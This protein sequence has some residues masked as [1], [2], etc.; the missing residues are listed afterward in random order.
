MGIMWIDSE[1]TVSETAMAR[2]KIVPASRRGVSGA[3]RKAF[4]I[5][6]LAPLLL[7]LVTMAPT[8]Y[9]LDSAE[10]TTAAYTGGLVRATGYP[11]YLVV[12]RAWSRIPL[13]DV[14]Y[15]MNLLSAVCG[16]LTIGLAFKILRKLEIGNWASLG[17]LGLLATSYYFWGLS[18]IAEVYTPQT[19]LTCLI[20]LVLLYWAN[21]PSAQRLALAVFVVALSA[22]H[23]MATV[24]LAPGCL[25]FVLRV[26][27][28]DSLKPKALGYAGLSLILGLSIYLYL[29]LASLA[30][31][32]FNYAGQYSAQG[33]FQP[34]DLTTPH[35][36]WWLMSGQA[37]SDQM[38][39]YSKGSILAEVTHFSGELW[40]AFS[41]IGIGPGIVGIVVLWAKN[42][43]ICEMLLIMFLATVG[44]YVA[45]AVA[46]KDTM[47]LPAYL[48]WA[49]WVAVG[50]QWLLDW[51]SRHPALPYLQQENLGT[52]L[53]RAILLSGVVFSLIWH[54]PLVSLSSDRSARIRGEMILNIAAPESVVIGW[55][56]TVPVI[57]Y[58][59]MVEGRREDITA[60]NRFLIELPNLQKFV[61]GQIDHRVVYLDQR[62][63]S[64]FADLLSRRRGPLF[65]LERRPVHSGL[66]QPRL[67]TP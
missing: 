16:A 4:A 13:G 36:L 8:V 41:I 48:I 9:N 10:L 58:L 51:T 63:G 22:G 15:R 28:R 18:L 33:T 12:G 64:D 1:N 35:G 56:D 61:D 57:E 52:N 17:A 53:L 66:E 55:W 62:P 59:Q 38:M 27:P 49:I 23:H 47:F 46:D 37:F 45:Y 25:W 20:I 2:L 14:G 31:P 67:N 32:E 60:M 26:A 39:A 40:R 6:V 7:Y 11:L 65:Q 42:R 34:V 5:A 21:D 24:L 54:T 29:P 44:F 43:K 3:D 50:Y 30:N 19:A